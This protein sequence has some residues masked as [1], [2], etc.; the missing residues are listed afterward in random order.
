MTHSELLTLDGEPGRFSARVQRRPRHVDL[1][2]CTSCGECVKVCPVEVPNE[3]DR[4]LSTRKAVYKKYAQAIPGGYAVEKRGT[5][6][7]RATCPAHVSVQGWIALMN[8]GKYAEA[9]ALFKQEHPFPG[10]C[11]RVCHHPCEGDR[12]SVV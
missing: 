6:P 12:K 4:G 8:Q 3:Y 7:C 5:A 11:G 1:D 2:K 10:V 9:V